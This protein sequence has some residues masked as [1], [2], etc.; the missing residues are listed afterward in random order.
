VA[1]AVAGTIALEGLFVA[2]VSGASVNPMR[3]F[4][5]ALVDGPF[6]AY[7]IYLAGPLAGAIVMVWLQSFLRRQRSLS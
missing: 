5:P 7:W 2:P 3:S 6:C 4:G 1:L